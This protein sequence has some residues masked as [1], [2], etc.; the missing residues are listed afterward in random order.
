MFGIGFLKSTR[1][2]MKE[3]GLNITT[4]I[5]VPQIKAFT[6]TETSRIYNNK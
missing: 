4:S 2:A 5:E 3:N 6:I 1:M